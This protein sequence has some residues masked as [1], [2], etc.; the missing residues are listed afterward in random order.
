[1]LTKQ[2]QE[3]AAKQWDAY[4]KADLT[5]AQ[6]MNLLS[7]KVAGDLV[8][9]DVFY[10]S[11]PRSGLAFQAGDFELAI[12]K[13]AEEAND[14]I[15]K[16]AG[17]W[18]EAFGNL[19]KTLK[20]VVRGGEVAHA[21]P[22][23]QEVATAMRS[24]AGSG[25]RLHAIKDLFDAGGA[26]SAA[27]GAMSGYQK[28]QAGLAAA[29]VA[30]PIAAGAAAA[31]DSMKKHRYAVILKGIQSDPAFENVSDQSKVSD[32]Y[33]MMVKYS[34]SIALDPMVAK[35]FVTFLVTHPDLAGLQ[36]AQ[37]LM[38]A[39]AKFRESGEFARDFSDRMRRFAKHPLVGHFSGSG[40]GGGGK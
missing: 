31:H 34:P 14:G 8:M 38:E 5:T 25:G 12:P 7:E 28:A 15:V 11:K 21:G 26:A 22:S 2:G 4:E 39:E 23:F 27:G 33:H 35:S 1:M 13:T 20:N 37:S 30:V 29:V 17:F 6:A 9:S 3:A 18:S 10:E 32:A 16:L 19:G 24:G 40:G 36:S